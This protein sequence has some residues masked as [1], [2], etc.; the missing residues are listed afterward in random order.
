MHNSS[1]YQFALLMG[2]LLF[3][4][5]ISLYG[6]ILLLCWKPV[7]A[8]WKDPH[9]RSDDRYGLTTAYWVFF[10]IFFIATMLVLAVSIFNKIANLL[11][12]FIRRSDIKSEWMPPIIPLSGADLHPGGSSLWSQD[13]LECWWVK[14]SLWICF[15]DNC[16]ENSAHQGCCSNARWRRPSPRTTTRRSRM[17]SL[18]AWVGSVRSFARSFHY[19]HDHGHDYWSTRAAGSTGVHP[20]DDAL[21]PWP[22]GLPL[23]PARTKCT[24][25]HITSHDDSSDNQSEQCDISHMSLSF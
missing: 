16:G 2:T 8:P 12:S 24:T 3:L 14:F 25:L 19:D 20:G 11:S 6:E 10:T 22:R 7:F 1:A 21:Q 5:A 18:L 9:L 13:P 23:D 17:S 15:V 4:E